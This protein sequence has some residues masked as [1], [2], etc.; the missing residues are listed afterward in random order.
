MGVEV[1]EEGAFPAG[2]GKEGHGRGDADVDA[3]HAGVDAGGIFA[4]GFAALGE[5]GGGVSEGG[6]VHQIDGAVE[7]GHA[8]DGEDGAEDFFAGDGHLQSDVVEDGGAEE[9]TVAG[10]EG[11]AVAKGS[12]AFG[13][14]ALD[15][16]LH[17]TAVFGG[18]ERTHFDAGA[19]AVADGQ[20]ARAF[21]EK[22]E[23]RAGG[24]ANGDENAAGETPFARR[25]EGRADD[26]FDGFRHVGVGHDDEMVLGAAERLDALAF[27]GGGGID[28]A[29]DGR[30]ADERDGAD[31]RVTEKGV[32]GF[33]AAVNQAEDAGRDAGF[34]KQFGGEGG[35]ERDFFRRFQDER[36][37]AGDGER[38]HPHG[39]HRGEVEGRDAGADADGLADG[40]AVDVAGDVVE[41]IA[42]HEAGHA[43]GDFDHLDGAA[44]FGAGVFDGFAVFRGERLGH[45]L[46][47]FFEERFIAIEDLDALDD[48]DGTPL[49]IRRVGGDDGAVDVLRRRE[50]D[51]GEDGAGG[52]IGD[53][54]NGAADGPLPVAGAKKRQLARG[55]GRGDHDSFYGT[56]GGAAGAILTW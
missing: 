4:G 17:A 7:R 15:V 22:I 31:E 54:M 39:H 45:A 51:V 25:S 11:A 35:R 3:D 18:D 56:S 21:D 26:G 52:G 44:D 2:E 41:R 55:G 46:V 12:G 27:G 42:H 8:D 23:Q 30:R 32:D 33:L 43:A 10:F 36:V 34:V 5:D 48:G 6:R 13:D 38:V 9:E 16:A 40:V 29:G 20:V 53:G 14:A 1:A 47:V 28:V 24:F 50:R 37:A 49:E 19:G